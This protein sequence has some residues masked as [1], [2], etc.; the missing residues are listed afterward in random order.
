[1]AGNPGATFRQA[2]DGVR[3]DYGCSR[4][5]FLRR[6]RRARAVFDQE[7]QDMAEHAKAKRN[8]LSASGALRDA[9]TAT[10]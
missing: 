4:K 6:F 2:I 10:S 8:S 7:K 3:R 1:V 9:E 5:E